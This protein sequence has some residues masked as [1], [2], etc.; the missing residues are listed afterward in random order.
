MLFFSIFIAVIF[1]QLSPK[2]PLIVLL[3]KECYPNKVALP[4][5]SEIEYLVFKDG[6]FEL[7]CFAGFQRESLK[8]MVRKKMMAP[9]VWK[10]KEL[11]PGL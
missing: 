10:G 8:K 5:L 3:L 1:H 4:C 6:H 2:V 7:T 9:T 11:L